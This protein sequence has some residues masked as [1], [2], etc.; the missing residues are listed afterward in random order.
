MKKLNLKL[1]ATLLTVV[2]LT[3]LTINSCKREENP[4][5]NDPPVENNEKSYEDYIKEL[6]ATTGIDIYQL[7]DLKEVQKLAGKSQNLMRMIVETSHSKGAFTEEKL[8]QLELLYGEM[9]VAYA[10]GNEYEVLRLFEIFCAICKTIDNFIFVDNG[11]GF[12]TLI[13]DPDKEPLELPMNYLLEEWTNSSNLIYVIEENYPLFSSLQEETKI[14]V[15]A[16]ALY[17][18]LQISGSKAP[19]DC[20]KNAAE[21]FA[22]ALVTNQAVYNLGLVACGVTGPGTPACWGFATASLAIADGVAYWQYKRALKKC[23]N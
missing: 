7:S 23:G 5:A 21:A 8:E 12:Q 16:A 1:L 4:P 9:E 14:E 3:S 2:F 11:Y 15:I 13:F 6:V 18:N 20:K 17:L 19:S 10:N 22:I